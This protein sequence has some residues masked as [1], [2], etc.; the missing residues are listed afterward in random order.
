LT[1][2]YLF[3]TTRD[4]SLLEKAERHCDTALRY[5]GNLTDAYVTLG[6]IHVNTGSLG[7]ARG[8][9][10]TALQQEPFNMR[11]LLALAS[12]FEA[13]HENEQ[14]EAT[15]NEA[16]RSRPEYW[17]GYNR[18][19]RF[20]SK[21]A[22]YQAAAEQFQTVLELAPMNAL[23]YRNLG[24]MYYFLGRYEDA[25]TNW[26]ESLDITPHYTTYNNLGSLNFYLGDYPEAAAAYEQALGVNEND[27]N[28]WGSLGEAYYLMNVDSRRYTDAWARAAEMAEQ[29]LEVNPLD[30]MTKARLAS[31]Y[32]DLGETE[33]SQ[34]L[35]EEFG[36]APSE[37]VSGAVGFQIATTWETLG[38]RDR[39]LSWIEDA[40]AKGYAVDEVMRYPRIA[41][42]RA[43]RAFVRILDSLRAR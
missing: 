40:L 18:L 29:W 30:Q 10:E 21:M 27:H 35:V 6:W 38:F 37:D 23:G 9:L 34:N 2:Y 16:I 7:Q 12:V 15:Y 39:A 1:D 33:K 5:D 42:L 28:I 14:A 20:Y 31:Y 17:G 11:A 36:P 4:I 19:G 22:D 26:R 32:A 3:E 8:A 25:E 13:L 43:D 41:E 24:T